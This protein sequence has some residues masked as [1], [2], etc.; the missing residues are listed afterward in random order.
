[1]NNID[2]PTLA[3]RALHPDDVLNAMEA[4]GFRVDGRLLALNSYENRV[5]QVGIDDGEPVIAKFYRPERWSDAAII[6]EHDF[7]SALAARDLPVVPPLLLDGATLHRHGPFRVSV[8]E[9][10]PGR[11]PELD[12]EDLLEQVGRLVARIHAYGEIDDFE[13]RPTLDIQSFGE[14]SADF[15]LE[16]GFLPEEL[17]VV[18]EGLAEHLLDAVEDCFD[19]AGSTRSIRLHGDLHPSNVLAR[20]DVLHI[21]DLDDARMGP[22]VQDLWMFLSGDRGEQVPQLDALL[23][24]Y[25]QFRPF[26]ARELHLVEGLRTLRIMHYAAWLARRWADPAFKSAFPWFESR[27]YW[28]DHIL[29]LKEQLALMQEG[30]LPWQG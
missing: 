17:W 24:G 1:M 18:Y 23:D 9:Q 29:A 2:D 6:E 25:T 20:D 3:F 5:Y 19:R 26:D 7:A 8:S 14:D 16:S 10:K 27:R 22:S 4:L 15:L 28:D 30:P 12:N 13:Y 21:I 11:P